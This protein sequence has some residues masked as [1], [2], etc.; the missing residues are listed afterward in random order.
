MYS[1]GYQGLLKFLNHHLC[2]ESLR[3]DFRWLSEKHVQMIFQD[4]NLSIF[5]VHES[6]CCFN[7]P[8]PRPIYSPHKNCFDGGT[9]DKIVAFQ[10]GDWQHSAV[11]F[12]FLK[13]YNFAHGQNTTGKM[14]SKLSYFRFI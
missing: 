8:V 9:S 14:K 2:V 10:R 7:R 1:S 3:M 6:V 12:R 4:P 11:A 5:T 13:Q